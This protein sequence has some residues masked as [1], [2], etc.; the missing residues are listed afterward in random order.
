MR[1]ESLEREM[2][3]QPVRSLQYML[4]RLSETYAFLPEVVEDG[5]FGEQTLEAVVSAGAASPGDRNRGPGDL[6]RHSG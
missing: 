1:D 5:I 4:R 6:E 2:L 3:A